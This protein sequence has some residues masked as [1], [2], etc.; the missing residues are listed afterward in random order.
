LRSGSV[1]YERVAAIE[2]PYAV[3]S[4]PAAPMKSSK[5]AWNYITKQCSVASRGRH[6]KRSRLAEFG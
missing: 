3:V 1:I 5:I 2:I 4:S 6:P